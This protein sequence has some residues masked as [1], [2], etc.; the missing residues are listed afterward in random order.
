MMISRDNKDI[1]IR[2]PQNVDIDG[3]QRILNF[4]TYKELS[5]ETK[6]SQKD[7]DKLAKEVNNNWWNQNKNKFL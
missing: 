3:L 1:I 7:V 4:L 5:S 2:I 6:A